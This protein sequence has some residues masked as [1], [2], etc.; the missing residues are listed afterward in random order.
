MNFL[1][2]TILQN[3]D[4]SRQLISKTRIRI[5]RTQFSKMHVKK[6]VCF[7][8]GL[9]HRLERLVCKRKCVFSCR[10]SPSVGAFCFHKVNI[11]SVSNKGKFFLEGFA[12]ILSFWSSWT[13]LDMIKFRFSINFA[14]FGSRNRF[15]MYY[16]MILHLFSSRNP[17]S[18]VVLSKTQVFT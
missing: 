7:S 5:N 9:C 8:G 6:Q 2:L 17:K 3:L 16:I 4:S 1:L 13:G 18:I 15:L 10:V 14:L 11:L 12:F